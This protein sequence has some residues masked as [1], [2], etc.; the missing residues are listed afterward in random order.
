MT[1]T[2]IFILNN[3]GKV[4]N[5][6]QSAINLLNIT[7]I[8]IKSKTIFD[9][10]TGTVSAVFKD[11][12]RQS[13]SF[14]PNANPL[15]NEIKKSLPDKIVLY[16]DQNDFTNQFLNALHRCHNQY[17]LVHGQELQQFL[18]LAFPAC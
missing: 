1:E 14:Y 15:G 10:T 6:N 3:D 12:V 17:L 5:A 4:I 13:P 7:N 16:V 11:G 2:S 18:Q 9:K 8:E